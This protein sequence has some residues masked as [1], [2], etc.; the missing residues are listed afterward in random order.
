MGSGILR[1]NMLKDYFFLYLKS[2]YSDVPVAFYVL[3]LAVFSVGVIISFMKYGKKKGFRVF[4]LV[5]LIEII[6]LMLAATVFLRETDSN[7]GCNFIPFWSYR[8]PTKDLQYSMYMENIMNVLMFI[9]LGFS[10]GCAFKNIGWKWM[11]VVALS[12]SVIIEVMQYVFKK[13]YAEVDDVIHN[14]LGCIIGYGLYMLIR[15]GYEKV[16]K[17]RVDVL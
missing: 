17:R 10:L 3:L 6:V 11:I 1:N 15:L 14:T 16:F 12:L 5:V 9:P 13:G 8:M 4:A 2:N 7:V